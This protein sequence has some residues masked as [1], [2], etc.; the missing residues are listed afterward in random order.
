MSCERD[1]ASGV[2]MAVPYAGTLPPIFSN[3]WVRLYW[4]KP[5]GICGDLGKQRN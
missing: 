1:A 5:S 3:G 2:R 4:I